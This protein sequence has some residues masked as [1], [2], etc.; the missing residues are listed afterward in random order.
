MSTYHDDR[1]TF[2]HILSIIGIAYVLAKN[3]FSLERGI[4]VLS[5]K[6][7]YVFQQ[8]SKSFYFKC[9]TGSYILWVP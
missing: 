9:A 6:F 1:L 2:D 3:T 8:V 5:L 4:P 7:P